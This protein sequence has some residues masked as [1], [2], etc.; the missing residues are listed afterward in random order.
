MSF[1]I[2]RWSEI[3]GVRVAPGATW[4]VPIEL[5]LRIVVACVSTT[6]D[7]F[8]ASIVW[9]GNVL[10]ETLELDSYDD[11]VAA[12]RESVTSALRKLFP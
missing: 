3:G 1:N 12:G 10:S 8:T 11:A 9:D 7:R 2:E 5:R 4:S 6:P